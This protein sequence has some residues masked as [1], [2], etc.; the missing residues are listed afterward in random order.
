HEIHTAATAAGAADFISMEFVDGD[1]LFSRWFR[2]TIP[3]SEALEIATQ[4]CNGIEAAHTAGILHRDLKTS[5][6]MLAKR[7]D[8]SLRVVIMDFGL[9]LEAAAGGPSSL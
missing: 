8:G 1:T 2:E 5:N 6:V 4:L 7:S 9:A 3:Q